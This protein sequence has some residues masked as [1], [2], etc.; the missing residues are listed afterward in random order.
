VA[1]WVISKSVL[2]PGVGEIPPG[3]GVIIPD[4]GVLP[5]VGVLP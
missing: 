2:T 4:V 5:G 1:Q 3:V